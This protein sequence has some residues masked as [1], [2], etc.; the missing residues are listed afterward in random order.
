MQ[1]LSRTFAFLLCLC[2]VITSFS[3]CTKNE[4]L[5]VKEISDSLKTFSSDIVW[6]QLS[7]DQLTS[8]FGFEAD[9]AEEYETYVNSSDDHF[10]MIA[11][12]KPTDDAARESIIKGLNFAMS[13]ASGNF[14]N[15]NQSEYK[16][17]TSGRIVEADGILV[18]VI[19]DNYE[20]I[21]KYFNDI[22]AKTPK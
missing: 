6:T 18:L 20:K 1:H 14:K 12:I 2:L 17:I 3:G 16:K 15:S 9:I 4:N 5:T 8:Y 7:G 13:S 21:G 19:V 10:D 11:V 22:G